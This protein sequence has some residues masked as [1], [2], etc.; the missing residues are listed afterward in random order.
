[1]SHRGPLRPLAGD[2][3]SRRTTGGVTALLAPRPGDIVPGEGIVLEGA[4][5][6]DEG[7][8]TGAARPRTCQAREGALQIEDAVQSD[9]RGKLTAAGEHAAGEQVLDAVDPIRDGA[10]ADVEYRGR[11][12]CVET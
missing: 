6:V 10:V 8:L 1:A 11:G 9:G 2:R 3:A 7:M 5:S 4:A 12:R